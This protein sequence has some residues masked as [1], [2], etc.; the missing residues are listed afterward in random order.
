MDQPGN[1]ANLARGQLSREKEY[2]PV[3]VCASESG[4]ARW[5]RP[6]RPASACSFSTLRLDLVLTHGIPPDF[7][8]GVH[9]VLVLR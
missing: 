9:S 5:V 6:S 3:P 1:I 8:G 4:L 2:F 7:G